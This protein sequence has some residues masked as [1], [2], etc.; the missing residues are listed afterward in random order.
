MQFII[1]FKS[2]LNSMLEILERN[3][4]QESSELKKK[5]NIEIKGK[6]TS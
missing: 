3:I 4:Q 1:S 6:K 5:S 2:Q